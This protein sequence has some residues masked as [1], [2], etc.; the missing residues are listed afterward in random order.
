MKRVDVFCPGFAADCLETIE[1]INEEL[2][3]FYLAQAGEDAVF[4]YVPCLNASDE[5]VRAYERII[6]RTLGD[7]I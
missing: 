7:W 4:H 6:R 1:E 3:G 2:R 5:A